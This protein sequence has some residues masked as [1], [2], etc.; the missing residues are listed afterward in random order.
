MSEPELRRGGRLPQTAGDLLDVN[1]WL[2]LVIEEHPHHPAAVAYWSSHQGAPKYF[3]RLSAMSFVRL[4]TNPKLMASAPLELSGAWALYERFAELPGVG[5]LGE[6]D[7]VD[8]ALASLIEPG[9][10]SRLFTDA[11]FAALALTSGFRLVTFD[12]DFN[13]FSGLQLAHLSPAKQ[14]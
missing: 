1:V 13:R 9:L 7:G 12:R 5:L 14:D 11:Y 4:L 6:P 10:P 3:C 2:A 8:A